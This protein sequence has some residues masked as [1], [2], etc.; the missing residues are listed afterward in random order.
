MG[1]VMKW[2]RINDARDCAVECDWEEYA[3]WSQKDRTLQI[4]AQED[5]GYVWVSTVLLGIDHNF[6]E[7]GPP[8]IFE[9][10]V[11]AREGKDGNINYGEL[12]M[13]R[14]STIQE[15]RDGHKRMVDLCRDE[16]SLPIEEVSC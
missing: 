11:F 16:Y 3:K 14:Y 9:T 12:E 8:L 2:Y 4:I 1:L 10:M 15:A 13:E 5:V 7:D 6:E